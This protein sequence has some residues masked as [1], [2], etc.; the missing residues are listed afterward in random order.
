MVIQEK[1]EKGLNSQCSQQ[2]LLTSLQ[3][4]WNILILTT[5]EGT[6][7]NIHPFTFENK[8]RETWKKKK[9][10]KTYNVRQMNPVRPK[11]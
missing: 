9:N 2:T 11:W 5:I 3:S 6:C 8:L 10:I 7:L 4:S 1:D